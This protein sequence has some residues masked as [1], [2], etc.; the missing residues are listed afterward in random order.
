MLAHGAVG[1][2]HFEHAV[3]LTIFFNAVVALPWFEAELEATTAGGGGG[4]G[5]S[6]NSTNSSS[7]G[8]GGGG[9]SDGVSS[10]GEPQWLAW[11]LFELACSG[12]LLLEAGAKMMLW[13]W[14]WRDP[15]WQAARNRFDFAL[16][17]LPLAAQLRCLLFALGDVEAARLAL[18][19]RMLRLLRVFSAVR[20]FRA[21]WLS[22]LRL[23]PSAGALFGVLG[24]TM[25]AYD[26]AQLASLL[27]CAILF[28][29]CFN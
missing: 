7:S 13:G 19:L 22:L 3:L 9:G 23:L 18:S 24:V 5:A 6:G 4:G 26:D 8:G 12:V 28:C 20:R 11:L 2:R 27:T 17:A 10:A 21:I 1:H 14:R 25:L 16:C 29:L 15:Y